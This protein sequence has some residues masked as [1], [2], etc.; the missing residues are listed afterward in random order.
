MKKEWVKLNQDYTFQICGG[1]YPVHGDISEGDTIFF[2]WDGPLSEK[3]MVI[4]IHMEALLEL[5]DKL[6]QMGN[7]GEAEK[8]N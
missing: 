4:P 5:A 7:H 8:S 1:K 6:R 2:L 3:R